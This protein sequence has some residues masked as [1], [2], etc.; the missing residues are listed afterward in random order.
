[1]VPCPGPGS[2]ASALAPIG[3]D[4]ACIAT[5]GRVRRPAKRAGQVGRRFYTP[6]GTPERRRN[7]GSVGFTALGRG[8]TWRS[9]N[10]LA[11]AHS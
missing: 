4:V 7:K 9:E 3:T 6:S 2:V 11:S 10:K 5:H 1:M 8:A